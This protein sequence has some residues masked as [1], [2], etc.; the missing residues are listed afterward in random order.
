MSPR[1]RCD[2]RGG[3]ERFPV[4]VNICRIRNKPLS[5]GI[6]TMYPRMFSVAATRIGRGLIEQQNRRRLLPW[7]SGGGWHA[8]ARARVSR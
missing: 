6:P 1:D 4:G 5:G 2:N 7:R 8:S 3:H